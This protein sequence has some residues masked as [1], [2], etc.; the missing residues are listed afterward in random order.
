MGAVTVH[1]TSHSQER[2][3]RHMSQLNLRYVIWPIYTMNIGFPTSYLVWATL[4]PVKSAASQVNFWSN[5]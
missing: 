4:H 1:R 2:K 5:T 3:V